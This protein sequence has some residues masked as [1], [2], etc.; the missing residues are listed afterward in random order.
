MLEKALKDNNYSKVLKFIHNDLYTPAKIINPKIINTEV[1]LKKTNSDIVSMTG[2]GGAFFALTSKKS[3]LKDIYKSI[4]G[5][6]KYIFKTD[7]F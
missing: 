5:K 1:L 7:I 6:T 3:V 4:K 2:S